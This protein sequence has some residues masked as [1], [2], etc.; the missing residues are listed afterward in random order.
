MLGSSRERDCAIELAATLKAIKRIL[1]YCLYLTG[2]RFIFLKHQM[3]PKMCNAPRNVQKLDVRPLDI[4]R[5]GLSAGLRHLCIR[6]RWL[7][8][9]FWAG[10]VEAK[11]TVVTMEES[12]DPGK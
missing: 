1:T 3:E 12:D 6:E 5:T 2:S 11:E 7:R 8:L 10:V 4:I 9:R